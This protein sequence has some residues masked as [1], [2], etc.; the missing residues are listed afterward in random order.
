MVISKPPLV[1]ITT[2]LELEDSLGGE[3]D[4]TRNFVRRYIEMWPGRFER[5]YTAVTSGNKADAL[6]SAL[7][8]RSSA[9]MVGAARLGTVT[10]DL[11]HLLECRDHSEATIKMASLK[12]CGNQTA[13]QLQTLYLSVE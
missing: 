4:L 10:N 12:S 3:K 1:C 8:L 13:G 2:L 5:I 9:L 6:D 7:S 11:I